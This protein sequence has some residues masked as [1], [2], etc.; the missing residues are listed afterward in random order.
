MNYKRSSFTGRMTTTTSWQELNVAEG[1]GDVLLYVEGLEI[2]VYFGAGPPDA[3]SA[4]KVP[5]GVALKFP[6]PVQPVY[7]LGTDTNTFV[8]YMC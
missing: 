8:Y 4:F 5:T 1:N 6:L 2:Y 3:N 7:I